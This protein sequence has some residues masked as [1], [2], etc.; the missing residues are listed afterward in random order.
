MPK[1]SNDDSFTTYLLFA[2]MSIFLYVQFS[3]NRVN[4]NITNFRVHFERNQKKL[5]IVKSLAQ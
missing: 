3:Y 5:V 1:M 2:S 4:Q